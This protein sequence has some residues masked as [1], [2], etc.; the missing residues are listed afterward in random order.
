MTK[1]RFAQEKQITAWVMDYYTIEA[2]S[3]EDAIAIVKGWDTSL[4][5][6]EAND[7]RVEWTERDSENSYEFIESNHPTHYIVSS[8]DTD[9]EI[10]SR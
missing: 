5:E 9:D 3:L 2:D 10:I 8:C 6:M 1:F 7:S 4:D